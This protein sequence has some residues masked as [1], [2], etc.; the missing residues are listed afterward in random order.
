MGSFNKG[1]TECLLTLE[2]MEA[3]LSIT[4]IEKLEEREGKVKG[5]AVLQGLT[6]NKNKNKDEDDV[7]IWM[8]TWT[9][10]TTTII[11][12]MMMMVTTMTTITTI[13]KENS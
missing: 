10:T 13:R 9:T 1:E 12:M 8:W 3:I 6:R 4:G 2:D 11:I 5:P 7:G